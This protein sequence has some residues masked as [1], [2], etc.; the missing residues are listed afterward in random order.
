MNKKGKDKT[1]P[2]FNYYDY[3]KYFKKFREAIQNRDLENNCIEKLKL[4]SRCSSNEHSN[5]KIKYY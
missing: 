3:Y 4:L 2:M 5:Q 1:E